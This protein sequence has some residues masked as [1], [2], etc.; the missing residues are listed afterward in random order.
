MNTIQKFVAQQEL[1]EMSKTDK[2]YLSLG[3]YDSS[4]DEVNAFANCTDNENCA[5]GNCVAG[6]GAPAQSAN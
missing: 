2:E 4:V 1:T 5:G 3:G 6:C